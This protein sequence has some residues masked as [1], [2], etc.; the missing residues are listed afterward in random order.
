V[1]SSSL[2]RV[3]VL[4]TNDADLMIGENAMASRQLHFRHMAANAFAIGNGTG[5]LLRRVA[6]QTIM[7]IGGVVAHQ[8]GVRIMARR[9]AN[10]FI[11]AEETFTVRQAVGLKP[12]VH[13]APRAQPHHSVPRPMA[14]AA[15]IG[16]VLG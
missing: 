4:Y 12:H 16:H 15:E 2:I 6:R 3:A 7:I 5:F 10:P 8:I 13:L 1:T 11:I 14:A 9:A